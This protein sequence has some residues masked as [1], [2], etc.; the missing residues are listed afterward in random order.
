MPFLTS[1]PHFL[2]F[3]SF[4]STFFHVFIYKYTCKLWKKAVL[5]DGGKAAG[6]TFFFVFRTMS[7]Y[8]ACRICANDSDFSEYLKYKSDKA[9]ELLV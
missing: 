3:V 6:F 1:Q 8:F 4:S 7:R 9:P 5:R 2:I